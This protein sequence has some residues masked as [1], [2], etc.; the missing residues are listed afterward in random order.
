MG[1]KASLSVAVRDSVVVVVDL[2]DGERG[3][4]LTC[5]WLEDAGTRS[6]LAAARLQPY[7]FQIIQGHDR[8]SVRV[9]IS[10]S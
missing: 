4:H 7:D 1:I 3:P 10:T 8:G 2:E 9:S 5:G 6:T